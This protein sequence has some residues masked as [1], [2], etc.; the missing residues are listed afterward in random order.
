MP[1]RINHLFDCLN[2]AAAQK[3]DHVSKRLVAEVKAS[4]CWK[5]RST[6]QKRRDGPGKARFQQASESTGLNDGL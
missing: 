6:A 1:W 5:F 3:L 2:I 4:L